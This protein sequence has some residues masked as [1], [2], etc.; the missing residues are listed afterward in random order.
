MPNTKLRKPAMLKTVNNVRSDTGCGRILAG[1][2]YSSASGRSHNHGRA[3]NIPCNQKRRAT[4]SDGSFCALVDAGS[5]FDSVTYPLG[6]GGTRDIW[7]SRKRPSTGRPCGKPDCR[8]GRPEPR[9]P[10][11]C[12]HLSG[13]WVSGIREPIG[14]AINSTTW[15]GVCAWARSRSLTSGRASSTGLARRWPP[16]PLGRGVLSRCGTGVERKIRPRA[17]RPN[18]FAERERPGRR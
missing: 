14:E 6:S 13:V 11:H 9:Q 1:Q 3:T 7:P 18:G 15:N 5:I 4:E 16:P 12:G 8:C 2:W 17:D 10:S